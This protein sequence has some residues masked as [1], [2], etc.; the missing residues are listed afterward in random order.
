M[1][2]HLADGSR[3]RPDTPVEQHIASKL[4]HN[5]RRIKLCQPHSNDEELTG[6]AA[7]LQRAAI[8]VCGEHAEEAATEV[9]NAAHGVRNVEYLRTVLMEGDE[10]LIVIQDSYQSP[11]LAR[12]PG[13]QLYMLQRGQRSW[14]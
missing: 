5:E 14:V 4:Y 7:R 10:G 1:L 12:T 11:R 6:A 13:V 8:E 9:L 3:V 2:F